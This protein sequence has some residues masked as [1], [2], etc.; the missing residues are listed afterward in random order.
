M[1]RELGDVANI[2]WEVADY[3]VGGITETLLPEDGDVQEVGRQQE[4]KENRSADDDENL[5]ERLDEL[6]EIQGQRYPCS[7]VSET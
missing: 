4:E 1:A 5:D 3:L 6:R 7:R 2:I